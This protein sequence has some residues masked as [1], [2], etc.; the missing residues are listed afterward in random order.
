MNKKLIVPVLTILVGISWLLNS[1]G[2]MPGVDWIWTIGLAVTGII[3]ILTGGKNKLSYVTGPFLLVASMSSFL[4]QSGKI[5]I[6][7]EIPLLITVF[8]ILM[9]IFQISNPNPE[10]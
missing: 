1:L 7:L 2:I 8:G 6:D 4:R 10:K 3:C 9:L 5:S